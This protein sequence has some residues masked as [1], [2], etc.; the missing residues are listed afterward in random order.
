MWH[1]SCG[2]WPKQKARPAKVRSLTLLLMLYSLA[3]QIYDIGNKHQ[4][5]DAPGGSNPLLVLTLKLDVMPSTG[6]KP[7]KGT[8]TCKNCGQ[9]VVLDDNSDTLP[10]CPKC[11]HTEYYP[12]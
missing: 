9:K 2:Y 8:Y 11:N 5:E 12:W 10:P 6:E 7:G 1:P 4:K 3:R